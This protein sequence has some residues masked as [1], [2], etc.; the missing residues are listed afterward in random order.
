LKTSLADESVFDKIDA[1]LLL[2][3]LVYREVFRAIEKEPDDGKEVP[4]YLQHSKFGIAELKKM[5][6]VLKGVH[7]PSN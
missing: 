4:I 6:K 1:P 2:F 3:G 5:E 7:I